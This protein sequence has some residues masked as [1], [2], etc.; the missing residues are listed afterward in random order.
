MR[1]LMRAGAIRLPDEAR[2]LVEAVYGE[3]QGS[4]IPVGL[5]DITNRAQG[6]A[7]ADRSFAH[8]NAIDIGL[9]YVRTTAWQDDRIVPTRLGD[10]SITLRLGAVEGGRLVPLSGGLGGNAWFMS[11]VSARLVSVARRDS[12]E[13]EELVKAAENEM[14]DGGESCLTLV[15]RRDEGG[16]IGRGLD[17]GGR[18]VTVRYDSVTG[19]TL[20]RGAGR[21]V[22]PDR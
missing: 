17:S 12:P 7:A 18:G 6:I 15:L 19:L 9:G 13:D 10:P 22:Q 21:A 8:L 20:G 5:A 11:Q 16:W 1:T 2:A 14:P 3:T 4:D